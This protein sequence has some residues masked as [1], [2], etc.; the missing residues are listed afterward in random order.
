MKRLSW[1][2]LPLLVG[3][4]SSDSD[5]NPGIHPLVSTNIDYGNSDLTEFVAATKGYDMIGLGEMSHSGSKAFSLRARMLKAMHQESNLDLIAVEAGLYDGLVAWQ[6]YLTKEQTL[7]DAVTGPD[8]NYMFGHRL[9]LEMADLFNYVNDVDQQGSDPLILTGYDSRINSDPGCSVM[10]DELAHY[11]SRNNLYIS[12]FESIKTLAPKAMCSWYYPN[13]PYNTQDHDNLLP[14]LEELQEVLTPQKQLETIPPYNPNQPRPFRQYAS[15]WLQITKSLKAQVQFIHHD[16]A[17]D[18]TDAQSA[19]NLHWL[20]KEWFQNPGQIA[21]FAHNIHA[22]PYYGSSVIDA[23]HKNYPDISTYSM[24]QLSYTGY[25][26]AET[27]DTS[28]WHP[29]KI[30]IQF[31]DGSLEHQLYTYGYPDSFI[32][33]SSPVGGYFDGIPYGIDSIL[34]IPEEEPAVPR[35]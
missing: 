1:L 22:T 12:D 31:P 28:K 27:P 30:A 5:K 16:F 8:A 13:D 17:H 15:F 34:F 9:S 32:D 10:F 24:L 3:C 25:I 18:I 29:E 23:T 4:N 20:Q 14:L 11:L 26:A 19:E 6:N 2:L 35:W 33:L 21:I 7:L